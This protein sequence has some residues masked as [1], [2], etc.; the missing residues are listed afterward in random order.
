M[1]AGQTV[2]ELM[3]CNHHQHG[4]ISKEQRLQ[5]VKALHLMANVCPI[6]NRNGDGQ[7][8]EQRRNE[9]KRRCEEKSYPP[10]QGLKEPVG[11]EGS[12]AKIKQVAANSFRPRR[13]QDRLVRLALEQSQAT[14]LLEELFQRGNGQ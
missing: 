10:K 12:E 13:R 8:N 7:Q 2:R 1:F 14:Q 11:I 4:D 3:E 9:N 6:P 5:A